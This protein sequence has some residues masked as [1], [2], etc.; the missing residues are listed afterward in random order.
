MILYN[1]IKKIGEQCSEIGTLNFRHPMSE[2]SSKHNIMDT[3]RPYIGMRGL[4][5][6]VGVIGFAVMVMMVGVLW[7]AGVASA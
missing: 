1:K 7:S 3:R 2:G 4:M 5:R 6:K